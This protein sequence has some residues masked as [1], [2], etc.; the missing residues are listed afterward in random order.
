MSFSGKWYG[1]GKDPNFDEG[2]HAFEA[3]QYAAAADYFRKVLDSPGDPD[4]KSQARSFLVSSLSAQ[5]KESQRDGR[6]IE[7]REAYREA[8]E[9]EPRYPDLWLGLAMAAGSLND[10]AT[11]RGAVEKARELNPTYSRAI[12]YESLI[13]LKAGESE[14]AAKTL[15]QLP[16]ESAPS[17]PDDLLI[18]AIHATFSAEGDEANQLSGQADDAAKDSNFEIAA[19]LYR[20]AAQLKPGYADI[21]CKLGQMLLQLDNL[22]EA[23]AH[24]RTAI[25]INPNYAEAWAQLGIALKRQKKL[26]DAKQAFLKAYELDKHHPIA[27][28]EVKRPF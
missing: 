5:G 21:R 1:F 25:E 10:D 22:N 11:E 24:L 2:L 9:L 8:I 12:L 4:L 19:A 20:Q 23:E 17:G 27:K 6:T 3:R 18:D 7:A 15:A 13:A 16:V 26:G 28:M 14:I